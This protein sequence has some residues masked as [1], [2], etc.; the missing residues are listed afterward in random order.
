MSQK[1]K[2]FAISEEPKSGFLSLIRHFALL[3]KVHGVC[4]N[5]VLQFTRQNLI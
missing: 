3:K 5:R 4:A 2:R 1:Y